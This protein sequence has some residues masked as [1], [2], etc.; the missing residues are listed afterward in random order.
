MEYFSDLSESE[1]AQDTA[2]RLRSAREIVP[3]VLRLAPARSVID[4]GCGLGCWLAAFREA[5][6]EDALGLDGDYIDR[7]RMAIP[8]DRFLPH[9]LLHPIPV[10]RRFDLV[11]SL[12]VAEH[13]PEARAAGFIAELAGLGDVVLF[14][15]AI[16]HQGGTGHC[17][18][19]WPAYWAGHFARHGYVPVDCLRSVLWDNPDIHWWFAQNL[20]FFVRREA[21][22]RYP[23]LQRE[24]RPDYTPL[25]VVHPKLYL[26][27]AG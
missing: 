18:E 8:Q 6:I 26:I 13:L 16:P 2:R 24:Y 27:K 17:N 21:L 22:E 25:S 19:Q 10:R 5:G 15:A 12:E 3:R 20:L 4:V 7:R 14:S 1:L 23:G 9:D 11:L